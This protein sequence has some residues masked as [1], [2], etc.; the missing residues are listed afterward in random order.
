ME[1][2]LSLKLADLEIE[3]LG[4]GGGGVGLAVG[5]TAI[6]SYSI[7]LPRHL[8]CGVFMDFLQSETMICSK[9]F[10]QSITLF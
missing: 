3:V 7:R 6:L 9:K 2:L 8:G 4:G 10:I 5:N 1:S